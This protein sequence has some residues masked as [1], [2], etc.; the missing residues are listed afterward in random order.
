MRDSK[1]YF[2]YDLLPATLL[3]RR[4]VSF[5]GATVR[6]ETTA[7]TYNYGYFDRDYMSVTTFRDEVLPNTFSPTSDESIRDTPLDVG[8]VIVYTGPHFAS[9]GYNGP[10]N[11]TFYPV[12][13]IAGENK[14]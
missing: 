13:A 5:D 3:F 7:V 10:E 11:M 4:V 14:G 12:K 8:S 9:G 1:E 2:H 6:L